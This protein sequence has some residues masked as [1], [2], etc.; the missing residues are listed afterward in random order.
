MEESPIEITLAVQLTLTIDPTEQYPLAVISEV[1]T[2]QN[3]TSILVEALV[4]CL[5]ERLVENFC[6]EKHAYGNGTERFQRSATCTRSAVTTAGEHTFTLDYVEDTAASEDEQ[7]HFRPVEKLIQFDGKRR[8]QEDIS[9]KVADLATTLSYRDAASAGDGFEKTPSPDTIRR[10]VK[11]YGQKL[12]AFVSDHVSATE[13]DTVIPDGTKCHSQDDDRSQHEVQ[14]TLAEDDDGGSRSV[15]DVSVNA[16]WNNIAG[17]LDEQD[18]ITDDAA[19]VSD[20]ERCLV[21]AFTEEKREHQRDLVH[22]P[23]SLRH[24]LSVDDALN[25]ETR[26]GIISEVSGELYHLKNSVERHRPEEEYSA[27]RERIARTRE[28]IE[29][30]TWQLEQ[31]GSEKAAAYLRRGL[32]SMLTFAK[33]ALDGVEVRW[34][35]NPVERAM[36]EVAKRCKRD[37]M[38][39]SQVGLDAVLQLRLIKYQDPDLYSQF[40]DEALCRSA[41]RQIHCTVSVDAT[42]GEV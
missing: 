15:L 33:K 25:L 35:S 17:D 27:I 34:T 24:R 19:V 20:G 40:L 5:N 41:H 14:I 1:L 11:E 7:S 6:G 26:K 29:K 4:E 18:A 2:K 16:D 42:G 38:Q 10:R 31:F 23:R 13:A 12:S 37:W 3:I 9:V 32:P 21:M 8:Y 28:R 22:V 39:W 36:G 30:T